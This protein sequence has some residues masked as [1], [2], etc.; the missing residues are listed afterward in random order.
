MEYRGGSTLTAEAMKLA[1]DELQAHARADAEPVVALLNDGK[2]QDVWP[3][4][5]DVSGRLAARVNERFAAALADDIYMPELVLYTGDPQRVYTVANADKLV[6]LFSAHSFTVTFTV[7]H[8]LQFY[9]FYSMLLQLDERHRG[10]DTGRGR[11]RVRAQAG[12]HLHR[13]RP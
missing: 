5:V 8:I 7:L 4:V 10:A 12:R 6:N 13:S 3:K 9:I 11:C 2:S 1:L